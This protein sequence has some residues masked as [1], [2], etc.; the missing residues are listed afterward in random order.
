MS[1]LFQLLCDLEPDGRCRP[2]SAQNCPTTIQNMFQIADSCDCYP[3]ELGLG[4][5]AH[6]D[7]LMVRRCCTA[8]ILVLCPNVL[9]FPGTA[10]VFAW[11][12]WSRDRRTWI[13]TTPEQTV[14]EATVCTAL[15]RIG[16][17]RP[18]WSPGRRKRAAMLLLLKTRVPS[19]LVDHLLT[20]FLPERV[21]LIEVV[22]S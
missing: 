18:A 4:Y 12:V 15:D 5:V 1:D 19:E 21:T 2:C 11:V 7:S 3:T 13:C 14:T 10:L 22:A 20:T 17:Q 8:L 9:K 6:S 16:R